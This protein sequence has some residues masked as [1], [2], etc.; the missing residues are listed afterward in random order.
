[1]NVCLG[2]FNNE[3]VH[4]PPINLKGLEPEWSNLNVL[5]THHTEIVL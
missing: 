4:I 2:I 1:M 3:I 5:I